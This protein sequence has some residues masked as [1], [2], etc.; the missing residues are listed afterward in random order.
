MGTVETIWA[1][2]VL[3][4]ASVACVGALL[5]AIA[6][7]VAAFR[8]IRDRARKPTPEESFWQQHAA[9]TA[10]ERRQP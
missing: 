1:T 8:R 10:P 4:L 2:V 5:V 3:I 7:E 6:W 9:L